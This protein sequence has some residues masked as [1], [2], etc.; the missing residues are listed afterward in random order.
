MADETYERKIVPVVDGVFTVPP[1]EVRLIG[2]RCQGC[3]AVAF[4]RSVI[5][6]RPGCKEN[7]TEDILLQREGVLRSFTIQR[8][9][10]PPIFPCP[11]PFTPYAVGSVELEEGIEVAGIVTGCGIE[12]IKPGMPVTVT[13]YK[14]Y[15]DEEGSEVVTYAFY[16]A[17]PQR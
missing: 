14:L 6:H 15:E 5:R 8:Y 9:R 12:E 7:S 4:P 3:G 16:P 13:V 17:E 2:V 10:P 11:E 1:E